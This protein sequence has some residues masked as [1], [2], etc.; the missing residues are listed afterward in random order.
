MTDQSNTQA[1]KWAL[2][3]REVFDAI[4]GAYD[5]GYNDAR[6]A[7]TAPG[8]GAPGYKGRDV[9]ADHGGALL[10][11]L[12]HLLAAQ[13]TPEPVAQ[14]TEIERLRKALVYVA[15]ALHATP[16]H[17]LATGISLIDADTVRVKLDGWTVEASTNPAR[18]ASA[19]SPVA[20]QGRDERALFEHSQLE[21][22]PEVDLSRYEGANEE[23]RNTHVQSA[24]DGW[25]A[26]RASLPASS[27][28][29]DP[30]V[31]GY[32]L[33]MAHALWEQHYKAD[34]PNWQPCPD[35]IG[36]LTQ[37]DNMV[38][39][40][41]RSLPAGG[42]VEHAGFVL[43]DEGGAMIVNS[44]HYTPENIRALIERLRAFA[45]PKKTTQTDFDN[46]DWRGFCN[47]LWRVM[48]GLACD[49]PP[50]TPQP[51]ETQGRRQMT[52]SRE[53]KVRQLFDQIQGHYNRE[54]VGF[55]CIEEIKEL[56]GIPASP[57]D[58]GEHAAT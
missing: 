26:A 1:A 18:Q 44:H 17:Q 13:P 53:D 47:V 20:P 2:I 58:G 11:R 56:L 48:L 45:D 49:L 29:R 28:E 52:A 32:A 16:Q 21:R 15:F 25:Q 36:V 57:Q 4:R 30:G 33:Q 7:R 19:P 42:V 8:D 55:H 24:W 43:D 22:F 5:L 40:V 6:N 14:A 51:S 39:G 38:A 35:L 3:K 12:E 37:I 31:L 50:S 23:Y 34:A 9:E 46:L 54:S 27:D 10:H 41:V